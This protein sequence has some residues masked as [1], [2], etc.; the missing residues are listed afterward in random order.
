MMTIIIPQIGDFLS[1]IFLVLKKGS[2]TFLN[3]KNPTVY[4]LSSPGGGVK[5]P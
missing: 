1:R 2:V 4:T 3:I 5:I